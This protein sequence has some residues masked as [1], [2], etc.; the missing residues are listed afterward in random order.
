[1]EPDASFTPLYINGEYRASSTD[2]SFTFTNSFTG[3]VAGRAAAASSKDCADAIAAAAQAFPAW[4][5]SSL[6]QRESIIRRASELLQGP[7]YK[8]KIIQ[9]MKDE[10]SAMDEMN[11]F[12][13]EYPAQVM[14]DFLGMIHLLKGESFPSSFGGGQ[15]IVQ[16]RAKGVVWV[17]FRPC[18]I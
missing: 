16:R 3:K 2:A 13:V 18:E 14:R 15:V 5:R 1:M 7:K 17:S 8:P 9:A 4:E 11:Y 6:S 12:C 10:I